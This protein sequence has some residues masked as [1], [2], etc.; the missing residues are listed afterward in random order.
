MSVVKVSISSITMVLIILEYRRS[1]LKVLP[2]Q[3]TLSIGLLFDLSLLIIPTLSYAENTYL[4][5]PSFTVMLLCTSSSTLAT[6]LCAY[7]LIKLDNRVYL[8]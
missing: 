3:I 6:L 7:I 1:L 8:E 5:G 2:F 4:K